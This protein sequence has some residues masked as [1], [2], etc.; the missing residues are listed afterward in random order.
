MANKAILS[1]YFIYLSLKKSYFKMF[2]GGVRA[3]TI[4]IPSH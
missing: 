2:K 1:K 3:I 4:W